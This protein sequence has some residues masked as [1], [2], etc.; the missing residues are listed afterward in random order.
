MKIN[1]K[2]GLALINSEWACWSKPDSLFLF[3]PDHHIHIKP[4]RARRWSHV[5]HNAQRFHFRG[6]ALNL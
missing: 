4:E 3:L 5:A 6:S 1:T 2:K